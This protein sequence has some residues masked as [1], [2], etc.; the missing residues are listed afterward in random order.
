MYSTI[1]QGWLEKD[2]GGFW[3]ALFSHFLVM[4]DKGTN[5]LGPPLLAVGVTAARLSRS[6]IISVCCSNLSFHGEKQPNVC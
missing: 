1:G 3:G 5:N 6:I 2:N 4:M